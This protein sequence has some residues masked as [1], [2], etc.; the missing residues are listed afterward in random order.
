MNVKSIDIAR[1]LGIS[2]STVSLALNVKSRVK[3]SLFSRKSS[4]VKKPSFSINSI[5]YGFS[6]GVW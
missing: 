6:S 3:I 1:A 4:T 5:T 2:K